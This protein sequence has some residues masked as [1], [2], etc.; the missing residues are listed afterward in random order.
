[1]SIERVFL[2]W[3]GPCL[4]AAAT[5]LARRCQRGGMLDLASVLC[6]LPTVRS[7]ERFLEQLLAVAA[8]NGWTLAPPR[9]ATLDESPS[10]LGLAAANR[11]ALLERRLAWMA[12]LRRL[13]AASLRQLT[14]ERPSTALLDWLAL[15]EAVER[16]HGELIRNGQ[17]FAELATLAP[18]AEPSPRAGRWA[19]LAQAATLYDHIVGTTHA[20]PEAGH[21]AAADQLQI[22]ALVGVTALPRCLQHFLRHAPLAVLP[23]I[24]APAALR[25]RF[26]DLGALRA[27]AWATGD[28]ELAEEQLHFADGPADQ[29]RQT[30]RLLLDPVTGSA[31]RG[32]IGVP[33][34]EVLPYLEGELRRAG[35]RGRWFAGAP[36]RRSSPFRLLAAV[37]E[38]LEHRQ[39][40]AFAEIL[41]HPDFLAAA[42]RA[43]AGCQE[44]AELSEDWL[45]LL[46]RYQQAHLPTRV[47]ER[48]LGDAPTRS[49]LG[50]LYQACAQVLGGLSHGPRYLSAWADPIEQ[51]LARVFAPAPLADADVRDPAIGPACQ[52][53]QTAL[54]E[55]RSLPRS[56]APRFKASEALRLL[57][58]QLESARLP[59]ECSP[60]AVTFLPWEELS[61]DDAPMLVIT[62][63]NEGAVPRP[64]PAEPLLSL[65]WREQLGL[66]T[67]KELD[68]QDRYWLT[69]I[70][71]SRPTVRLVAGRHSAEGD[72]QLPSR[73]L[74]AG[75]PAV[76]ARRLLRFFNPAAPRTVTA[77]P[78]ITMPPA[79]ARQR[80]MDA[81]A[82]VDGFSIPPPLPVADRMR[83]LHVTA[84]RDYIACPYRFYLRHVLGLGPLNDLAQE[85]G[86]SEFGTLAHAVLGDFGQDPGIRWETDEAR[87]REYFRRRLSVRAALHYGRDA[88]PAVRVQLDQ[89]RDRLDALARWQASWAQHGWQ[90]HEAER[91]IAEDQA[92]LE[93]D[94]EPF[95][96]T[97][98]IDRLDVH[99]ETGAIV[100]FDYKTAEQGAGPAE[101]HLERGR[102]VELQLPLYRHLARALGYVGPIRLGYILVPKDVSKVGSR[103]A[104][105]DESSLAA[106]DAAA[107][108]V[109]RAIRQ[110]RFWP[111][112]IRP[113]IFDDFAAICQ[114]ERRRRNC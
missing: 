70:L 112:A 92:C 69:A 49:R 80:S 46:D 91:E 12:A 103:L 74:L 4:P 17:S 97:G 20:G 14:R 68:A 16:L 23:L 3:T 104:D 30:V 101:T 66:S 2:D 63:M 41:R 10:V 61:L 13:P 11:P 47:G 79:G 87:I 98:R 102:W 39:F 38:Y 90:I 89:L 77:E 32:A 57:L 43:A 19:A 108:A 111:P 93:V 55:M 52:L 76:A 72:P 78:T 95:Y 100:L 81:G 33:N 15:A 73:L 58:R 50:C 113:P 40:A 26:D 85:L 22:I 83:R 44:S 64:A 60:P 48:W 71:A 53:L 5:A 27:E 110:N 1:M 59:L 28:I 94:G 99:R 54:A 37:V 65:P 109:V 96:L 9:I 107:F 25:D 42:Q 36:V 7:S 51:F 84:F 24:H 34:L 6:I 35:L 106:A 62:G 67:G 31:G 18:P 29:A 82:A 8:A 105:W 45:S 21:T 86:P 56:L 88:M 114:A 75:P